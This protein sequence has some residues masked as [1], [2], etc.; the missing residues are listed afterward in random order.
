MWET[1]MY[2]PKWRFYDENVIFTNPTCYSIK[3]YY[4]LSYKLFIGIDFFFGEIIN[5][6]SA[7]D[8]HT[9]IHKNSIYLINIFYTNNYLLKQI[10]WQLILFL[11]IYG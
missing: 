6:T 9:K 4:Y 5:W 11:R 3:L 8:T 7:R 1:I 10:K 2:L